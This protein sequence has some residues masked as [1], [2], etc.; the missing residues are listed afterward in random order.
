MPRMLTVKEAADLLG[1]HPGTVR[2]W[3]RTGVLRAYHLG[4]LHNCRFKVEELEKFRRRK[5][6]HP[7]KK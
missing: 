6:N 1:V 5:L 7:E 4:K 3:E 2:L